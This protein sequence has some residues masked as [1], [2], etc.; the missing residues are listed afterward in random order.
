MSGI[1]SEVVHH[2]FRDTPSPVALPE[3]LVAAAG[4]AA[5]VVAA[6]A[7]AAAVAVGAAAAS[8]HL[9]LLACGLWPRDKEVGVSW[10]LAGPLLSRE[11]AWIV[12]V[13]CSD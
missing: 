3:A 10:T 11:H 8:S 6:A 7:D 2:A 1:C 5:A 4:V 13:N 9:L 12:S